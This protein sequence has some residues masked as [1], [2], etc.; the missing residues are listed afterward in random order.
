MRHPGLTFCSLCGS[1][2]RYEISQSLVP[3]PLPSQ[4]LT[5]HGAF[6]QSSGWALWWV[7]KEGCR[8]RCHRGRLLLGALGSSVLSPLAHRPKFPVPLQCWLF[9]FS[10]SQCDKSGHSLSSPEM[11]T[12]N[13]SGSNHKGSTL[14]F[15]VDVPHP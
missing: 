9:P 11:Q 14:L 1:C 12:S 7:L 4:W 8:A 5:A 10:R 6:W 13:T 2:L 15:K 3:I